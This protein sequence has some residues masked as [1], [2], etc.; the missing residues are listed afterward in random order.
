MLRPM[1]GGERMRAG[2]NRKRGGETH[3]QWEEVMEFCG[4]RELDRLVSILLLNDTTKAC[5]I[6]SRANVL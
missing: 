2:E 3:C 5:Q 6:A 4:V 1:D